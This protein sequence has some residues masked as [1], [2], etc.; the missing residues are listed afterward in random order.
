[1]RSEHDGWNERRLI[2]ALRLYGCMTLCVSVVSWPDGRRAVSLYVNKDG[3][4]T[5]GV[6]LSDRF[7]RALRDVLDEAIGET[8][9][10]EGVEQARDRRR[11]V[12]KLLSY[13]KAAN[14]VTSRPARRASS[15]RSPAPGTITVEP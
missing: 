13:G 11:F 10:V 7:A 1:M 3:E 2:A 4:P 9:V 8:G 15:S 14:G 5:R 6:I 12:R